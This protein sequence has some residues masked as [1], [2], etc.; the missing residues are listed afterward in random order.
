MSG[1]EAGAVGIPRI[2]FLARTGSFGHGH[3][4]F[5]G[6]QRLQG[7]ISW[8]REMWSTTRSTYARQINPTIQYPGLSNF[9]DLVHKC[10]SPTFLFRFAAIAEMN[11][12]NDH[13]VK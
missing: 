4:S 6:P 13:R 9:H 3:A 2:V 5:G 10:S 7:V 12:K 8:I 1:F 11:Q